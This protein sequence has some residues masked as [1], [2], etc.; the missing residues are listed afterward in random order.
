[1]Q[2]DRTFGQHM[3]NANTNMTEFVG[4]L[5]G[6]NGAVS[7]LGKEIED[8]TKLLADNSAQINEFLNDI[9]VFAKSAK[10]I[11]SEITEQGQG[12]PWYIKPVT[13]G[14]AGMLYRYRGFG[15]KEEFEKSRDDI[16]SGIKRIRQE[17]KDR[18]IEEQMLRNGD[19]V[20][21]WMRSQDELTDSVDKT[22]QATEQFVFTAKE[23]R[24]TIGG[25]VIKEVEAM[26]Q[27][28][29]KLRDTLYPQQAAVRELM[30]EY[31][32]LLQFAPEMR[33]AWLDANVKITTSTRKAA[34][35]VENLREQA[36]PLAESWQAA[37]ER[38]DSA[39]V[40][41]WKSAFDGFKDFADSLKNAFFQLLAEMA[42]R[43][44]TQKILVSLGLTAGSG[45]AMAGGTGG[46]G[47]AGGF[48]LS[49]LTSLSTYTKL[50][51]SNPLAG[52]GDWITKVGGDSPFLAEMGMRVGDMS[53]LDIGLSAIAGYAGKYLGGKGGEALFGKEAESSGGSAIGGAAGSLVEV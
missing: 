50:L 18:K 37:L 11:I 31:S 32:L 28:F 2:T 48:D 33:D 26:A 49:S 52:L 10:L 7:E 35:Q 14:P 51:Q 45:T 29:S 22:E 30:R 20:I 43:A 41:L 44:T 17:A 12:D 24:D 9:I 34:D 15:G 8:F 39:F 27:E 42:H 46:M 4:G 13:M 38:I 16:V 21:A 3:V 5:N 47:G 53:A 6:V 40:D 19:A 23:L 36:D 1:D 25:E